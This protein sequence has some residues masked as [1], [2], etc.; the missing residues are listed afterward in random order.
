MAQAMHATPSL[1]VVKIDNLISLIDNIKQ[2]DKLW[3]INPDKKEEQFR[4]YNVNPRQ[5]TVEKFYKDQ[6]ENIT[7]DFVMKQREKY[8]KFDRCVMTIWD[9][10]QYLGDIVDDSDPDTDLSQ[11]Q[12]AIQCGEASR[13]AYPDEK[14]DWLHVT[15]FIH[16]LG[17]V[18]AVKD[19]KLG[20][21]GEPQYGVVG[22]IFPVGCKFSEK[23]VF[24][25]YFKNNPDYK[26]KRYNTKYGVYSE[27][28]GLDNVYLAWS[29]D[30]YLY[31]IAKDQSKLPQEALCMLRYHSF[32]PWHTG[33]DYMYLC[34]EKDINV[35]LKWTRIFNK[36]DLYSKSHEC[37]GIDQVSAYYQ[38]KIKKYF[39]NP[40]RW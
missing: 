28:C 17:K 7:F 13:A 5:A 35:A 9:M 4:N 27:K 10:V 14:Y 29:H 39:P 36:F 15:A 19:D 11:L 38:E 23:C 26:D 8:L 12:H 3:A 31:N 22:D 40:V 18:M 2:K 33:G 30:E 21:V 34:N 25:E 6:H 1:L 20:F 32:Y 24:H 16:D 37:P